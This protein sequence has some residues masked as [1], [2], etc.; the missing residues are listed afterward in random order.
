[1]IRATIQHKSGGDVYQTSSAT[2]ISNTGANGEQI[3]TPGDVW[4]VS[5]LEDIKAWNAI[6]VSGEAAAVLSIQLDGTD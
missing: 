3:S 5:N 6:S 4:V 1:M 2:A